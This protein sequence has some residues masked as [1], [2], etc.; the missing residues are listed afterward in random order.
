[1][2][3]RQMVVF[4]DYEEMRTFDEIRKIVSSTSQLCQL[5]DRARLQQPMSLGHLRAMTESLRDLR[6]SLVEE[7]SPVFWEKWISEVEAPI[8]ANNRTHQ[9]EACDKCIKTV[10]RATKMVV[11]ERPRS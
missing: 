7:S 3:I 10:L 2:E 4:N 9:A 5:V 6:N 11:Q 8:Q 1:M